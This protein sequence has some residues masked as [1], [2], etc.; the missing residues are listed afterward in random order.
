MS[1]SFHLL[2]CS[3]HWLTGIHY[4][5][6]GCQRD[7]EVWQRILQVRSLVLKPNEDMDTWIEFADLCR[8]SDRLNLAEKTLTSLVGFQYPSMEDVSPF[9]WC[10]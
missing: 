4:R 5:L 6:A 9:R 10:L 3:D 7:V 1:I 2:F 8:T